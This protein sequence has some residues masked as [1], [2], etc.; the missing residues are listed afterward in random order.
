MEEVKRFPGAQRFWFASFHFDVS[1]GSSL[2]WRFERDW[3]AKIATAARNRSC[4]WARAGWLIQFSKF[5]GIW[6]VYAGLSAVFLS[7]DPVCER[8]SDSTFLC[9]C[10][11]DGLQISLF[12]RFS[13]CSSDVL[14]CHLALLPFSTGGWLN[15]LFFSSLCSGCTIQ[16]LPS[17]LR[18]PA[19]QPDCT[20][21]WGWALFRCCIKKNGGKAS[22]EDWT[23]GWQQC[24]VVSPAGFRGGAALLFHERRGKNATLPAWISVLVTKNGAAVEV[25][26]G[27]APTHVLENMYAH[28]QDSKNRSDACF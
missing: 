28:D 18:T 24:D 2:R 14:I 27:S 12:M 13:F 11:A 16:C 15:P 5:S 3:C 4:L 22:R 19:S 7:W 25:I 21:S 17:C 23:M 8:K 9:Q 26:S 1:Y 20:S 10:A 6:T